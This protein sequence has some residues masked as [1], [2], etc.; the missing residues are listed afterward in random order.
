MSPEERRAL[1]VFAPL[2]RGERWFVRA[3]MS[4]APLA[5]LAERT[6]AGRILDVGCGHGA[7]IALLATGRPDRTV[8]G[9]DPD[10]RKIEWAEAS[11]GRLPNVELRQA[12]IE[13]LLPEHER[14]FDA[15]VAAD[16][17]Y[18]LPTGTWEAFLRAAFRLLEPGGL[19]VIQEAEGDGSWRHL[20]W[21][22]Q[23]LVMVKV[24]RRTHTSG[25]LQL[26]PR[27]FWEALLRTVG[28]G[29][30]RSTTMSAGYTSPHVFIEGRR[31]G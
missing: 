5:R 17:L 20:K 9:I 26:A 6:P 13:A 22:L 12:T 30:V 24:F 29:D 31:P 14:A 8:L 1:E 19:L 23:E 27:G 10:R 2:P 16:V 11:V 4:S 25:G 15:V 21:A 18:L 28:F 7:L 3:R